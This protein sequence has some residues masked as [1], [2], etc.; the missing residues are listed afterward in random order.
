[1]ITVIKQ[2]PRGEAKI[3]YQGEV[4]ERFS[5]SVV[6]RASWTLP[7]RDLDYAVFEPGD[8]FT[9]YYYTD[10]WFNIFDITSADGLHKGWYCNVAEPAR[11][12]ED[13]IEQIDLL[14]DVWVNSK[15]ESRILDEDEFAADTTLSNEQRRGAQRGLQAI[16]HMLAE[17]HEVF[18]SIA[19]TLETSV[20]VQHCEEPH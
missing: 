10:R 4:I 2:N 1:M 17:R 12:Y 8:I 16:L 14:L 9:E 15:G 5:Q 18:S 6:L 11:I 7:V 19:D 3:Q 13:H 20:L